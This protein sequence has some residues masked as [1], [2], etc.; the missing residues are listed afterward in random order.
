MDREGRPRCLECGLP[1]YF[2]YDSE[3]WRCWFE[4]P[5]ATVL[6]VRPLSSEN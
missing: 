3:R 1:L 5:E 6:N 4:Y 2:G